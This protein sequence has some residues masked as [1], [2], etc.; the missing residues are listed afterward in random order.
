MTALVELTEVSKTYDGAG[1]RV[2]L[3]GVS[4]AIEGGELTAIMG[5][6]G[7][8]KST[9]LNLVAGV[10]RPS[11]GRVRVAGED[12]GRLSEARLARFRRARLGFVFQFFNLLGNLTVL[13]NVLIPA[14]LQGTRPAPA[15]ARAMELL[16]RLDIAELAGHYPARLSGGQ[17]QRVAVARALINQP[18]LLLADE[19]TGAMDTHSGGQVMELIEGLNHEGQTVLL[20]THDAKLATR[21]AGRVVTLIDGRVVDDTRLEGASP[22]PLR[23]RLRGAERRPPQGLLRRPPGGPRPAGV[24][25]RDDRRQ[26]V[27]RAMARRVPDRAPPPV[28]KR[29]V[30]LPAR[31]GRQGQPSGAGRAAPHDLGTLGPGAGRGR[32]HPCLRRIEPGP[33]RGPA[34]LAPHRRQAGPDRGRRGRRHRPDLRWRQHHHHP[35]GL[36]AARPGGGPG[37]RQ[38]PRL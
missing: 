24:H 6:S 26:L 20:V 10:D 3:D 30:A 38:R 37:G 19:P 22:L 15:R 31:P 14:Q 36:G 33:P 7:S 12:L 18:L 17:Q 8:G 4:L 13:E 29:A 5:P 23:P 2:A 1:G 32:R 28:L 9:L 21:H 16:A 11:G 34:R 27:R 35:A 25:A